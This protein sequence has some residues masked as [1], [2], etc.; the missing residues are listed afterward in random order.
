MHTAHRAAEVLY[1]SEAALRL[2]DQEIHDLCGFGGRDLLLQRSGFGEQPAHVERARQQ[3]VTMLS[4]L[5]E[6]RF[7][8]KN[9]VFDAGNADSSDDDTG[10]QVA[11]TMDAWERVQAS[12]DALLSAQW[13]SDP[14][15]LGALRRQILGDMA[16]L[17]VAVKQQDA[18]AAQLRQSTAVLLDVEAGLADVAQRL[19]VGAEPD[20]RTPRHIASIPI[21]TS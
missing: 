7:A 20:T 18:C 3:V 10:I 12:M 17:K 16:G 8:L 9:S 19:D 6:N 15:L 21:P 2:V 11:D 4:Q 5:R 14:D 1:E 13:S